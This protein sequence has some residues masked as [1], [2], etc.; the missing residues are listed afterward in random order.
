MI[1]RRR[2]NKDEGRFFLETAIIPP[3]RIISKAKISGK[4]HFPLRYVSKLT[5]ALRNR[6]DT[7]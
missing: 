4:E 2:R 3:P 5:Y 6:F 1:F 7:P